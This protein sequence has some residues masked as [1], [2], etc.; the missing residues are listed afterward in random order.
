[1]PYTVPH[2]ITAGELVTTA[3]MNNEW[4][5]N[6]SFLANPPS[7]RVYNTVAI[8]IPHNTHTTLTFNTNRWDTNGMHST[9]TNTSRITINTAGLYTVTANVAW[10][11]AAGNTTRLLRVVLNGANWIVADQDDNSFGVMVQSVTTTYKF[12]VGDFIEAAVYQFSGA[13]LNVN[14]GN[15][16]SPEFSATWIGLG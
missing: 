5:G 4:G 16:Y 14:V 1:M 9:V 6:V 8:S 11:S 13:A 7:C 10:A 12:A 3:T 15:N 2:T